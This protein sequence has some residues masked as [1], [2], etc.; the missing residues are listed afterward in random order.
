[1]GQETLDGVPTEI[2]H[3]DD[4][5]QH[6]IDLAG[7]VHEASTL[8]ADA[9]ADGAKS[10]I[11]AGQMRNLTGLDT[12]ECKCLIAF[13]EVKHMI[14]STLLETLGG[15]TPVSVGYLCKAH[16]DGV[17]SVPVF[18]ELLNVIIN[19]RYSLAAVKV[20][21]KDYRPKRDLV[22][23][24]AVKVALEHLTNPL[25]EHQ[26]SLEGLKG[27]AP[28]ELV[29]MA[30]DAHIFRTWLAQGVRRAEEAAGVAQLDINP[31]EEE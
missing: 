26:L 11:S 9:M 5:E 12:I 1:M 22:E 15:C 7:N 2:E 3:Q 24:G 8:L 13:H 21:L 4:F 29:E 16:Q 23:D 19:G 18:H 30:K 28:A 27:V 31:D 10:D 6:I 25:P 17:V 20:L 14:D